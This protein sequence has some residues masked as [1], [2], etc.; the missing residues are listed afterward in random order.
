MEV[1][2]PSVHLAFLSKALFLAEG[3]AESK[4]GL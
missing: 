3:T 2:P 1:Q 4:R